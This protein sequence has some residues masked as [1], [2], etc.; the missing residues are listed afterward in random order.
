MRIKPEPTSEDDGEGIPQTVGELVQGPMPGYIP[1]LNFDNV[2][3]AT[4]EQITGNYANGYGNDLANDGHDMSG[5]P[6]G[7]F[8]AQLPT[9]AGEDP[10]GMINTHFTDQ[11]Q[12]WL[13]ET[14]GYDGGLDESED[15]EDEPEQVEDQPLI[16][17]DSLMGEDGREPAAKRIPASSSGKFFMSD[18]SAPEIEDEEDDMPLA[19]RMENYNLASNA[20]T[21]QAHKNILQMMEGFSDTIHQSGMDAEQ[22]IPVMNQFMRSL[23]EER[24]ASFPY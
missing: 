22:V 6:Y 14:A 19:A 1:Q 3:D 5:A 13:D 10:L 11:F 24:H 23:H 17:I 15:I 18:F 4:Y 7:N 2:E 8:N 12:E 16:D 21:D 9:L 20:P